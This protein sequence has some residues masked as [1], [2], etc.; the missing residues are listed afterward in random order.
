MVAERPMPVGDFEAPRLCTEFAQHFSVVKTAAKV[1][2]AALEATRRLC[3]EGLVGR[4]KTELETTEI[5]AR[6]ANE[7]VRK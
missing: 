3:E 2:A 6:K 5:A 7:V 1:A 4:A